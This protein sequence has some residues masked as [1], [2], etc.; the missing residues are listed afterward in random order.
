MGYEPESQVFQTENETEIRS[1]VITIPGSID[2]TIVIGAH[3]DGATQSTAVNH[4]P[5][6]NDN[7]SGTI[8]QLLF[9]K[10]AF[11]NVISTDKT[12]KVIFWGG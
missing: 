10:D 8:V 6:A 7:A 1:V 11:R 9:L 3:F 4:Y 5:A 2:S 12:I